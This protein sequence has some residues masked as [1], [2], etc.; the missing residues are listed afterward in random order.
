[1]AAWIASSISGQP[2]Q[3]SCNMSV[4]S[5]MLRNAG[6][7]DSVGELNKTKSQTIKFKQQHLM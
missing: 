4:F 7:G 5:S 3:E 6:G 2:T 1:M